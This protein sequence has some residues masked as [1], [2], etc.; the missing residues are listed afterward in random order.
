[1]I[2]SLQRRPEVRDGQP[3]GRMDTQAGLLPGPKI[4]AVR[5]RRAGAAASLWSGALLLILG[6]LV[7]YPVAMLLLGALTGADP[8]VDGYRWSTLSARN[9]ITVLSN[10]NVHFALSNSL[11]A[12]TGGTALAVLIGLS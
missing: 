1:M 9:F 11:I 4:V 10:E 6:F 12:C 5:H 8:V 2:A 7:V 3:G